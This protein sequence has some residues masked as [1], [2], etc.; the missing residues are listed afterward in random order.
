MQQMENIFEHMMQMGGFVLL[1]MVVFMLSICWMF[2]P[3]ISRVIEY[4]LGIPHAKDET[5]LTKTISSSDIDKQPP[6]HITVHVTNV[7]IH[8]PAN[9]QINHGRFDVD[10]GYPEESRMDERLP[11]IKK[12]AEQIGARPKWIIL[13]GIALVLLAI[14]YIGAVSGSSPKPAIEE[15]PSVSTEDAASKNEGIIVFDAE[16][17][18]PS[19]AQQTDE[20]QI[21]TPPATS[22]DA[23]NTTPSIYGIHKD[24]QGRGHSDSG[25]NEPQYVG[26]IGYAAVGYGDLNYYGDVPCDIPWRIKTYERDKQ[27]W[28]ETDE[29]L[30][31]KTEVVVKNQMLKHEGYDNYSGYLEVTRRSDGRDFY[32]NVKNF[33]TN[34][35][36]STC[37]DVLSAVKVGECLAVYHQKSDFYPVNIDNKKLELPD[38]TL[39]IVVNTTGT[40]GRGRPDNKTHQVSCC[41]WSEDTEDYRGAFFNKD[42]LE[43]QY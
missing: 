15:R 8:N 4:L 34:P 17:E 3:T 18:K 33:I 14:W 38:G 11:L 35:Y 43:L 27:F 25:R 40:Y 29:G 5:M 41:F 6:E 36:W 31:H 16:K 10:K 7:N 32:I 22:G 23:S 12:L 42:D 26:V 24:L 37:N 9:V 21:N 19:V 39:V 2:R 28:I 1:V 20:P 13:G 30:E